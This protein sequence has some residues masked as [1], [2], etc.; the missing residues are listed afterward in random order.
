MILAVCII[1]DER[2]EHG[3]GACLL[4]EMSGSSTP[5]LPFSLQTLGDAH[6]VTV[7]VGRGYQVFECDK[8]RLAYIGPRFNEKAGWL[9]DIRF[10]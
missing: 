9:V 6:F 8:L 4:L 10:D 7:S 1:S 2:M 3:L 5:G